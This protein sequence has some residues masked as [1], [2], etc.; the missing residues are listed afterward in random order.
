MHLFFANLLEICFG[1]D[2]NNT[3]VCN[4][5]GTCTGFNSCACSKRYGGANCSVTSCYG[6][7]MNDVRT[8]SQNG[9]CIDFN[10]CVCNEGFVGYDC[11]EW[12]NDDYLWILLIVMSFGSGV[13][14]IL[15]LFSVACIFRSGFSLPMRTSN[16][17]AITEMDDSLTIP[18]SANKPASNWVQLHDDN[19][20]DVDVVGLDDVQS[21]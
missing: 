9:E 5:H 4:G 16:K 1:I 20:D 13:L 19:D 15:I 10:Q 7:W 8:C 14:V 18:T 17:H 12:R 11:R 3:Q 2:T 6:Y 21:N